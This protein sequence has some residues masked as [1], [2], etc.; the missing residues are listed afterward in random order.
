MDCA[1]K[2]DTP[3][4]VFIGGSGRSG[5]SI[6]KVILGTHPQVATLPFEYRFIIDPDGIV[7]FYSSYTSAWSP[8]LADRKLKRLER[9]LGMLAEESWQDRLASNL[10]QMLNSDGRIV[11]PRRY[12]GWHLEAHLPHFKQYC[13]ELVAELREFLFPACWVGT[14]SYTCRAQLHHVKPKSREQLAPILG[15][16][17]CRVINSYLAEHGKQFFVEDNTWNI[18]FARELTELVSGARFLHVYRDPRDVVASFKEQRWCPSDVRQACLW[19][20]SI[21]EHWFTVRADLPE[22]S[23]YEFGLERLVSDTKT[24]LYE[25]CEFTGIP[26]DAVLLGTD[27]SKAHSGRWRYDLSPAEQDV[28]RHILGDLIHQLGYE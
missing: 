20:R 26:Y 27:L 15:K 9:L 14:E 16:F 13:Q 22:Y 10:L 3:N 5:T 25:L 19:Y 24:T 12:H 18:L 21:M 28:V 17:I 11:S 6:T 23:Y 8:F 7:D 4:L 2:S 1:L